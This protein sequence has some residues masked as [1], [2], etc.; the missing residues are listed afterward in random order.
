[1]FMLNLTLVECQ[2]CHWIG[3]IEDCQHEYRQVSKDKDNVES[4]DLC[5]KCGNAQLWV[6]EMFN[7]GW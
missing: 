1:M 4:V 2:E 5:P 7:S 6:A 3:Q